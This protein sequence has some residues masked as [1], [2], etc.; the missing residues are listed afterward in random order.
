MA[1]LEPVI[2]KLQNGIETIT[3]SDNYKRWL[4]TC[5]AFHKY[6]WSNCILISC[7]CEHASR[8]AGFSTWKKLNRAV[9]KGEKGIQILAPNPIK[10]Y[11]SKEEAEEISGSYNVKEKDGK[12]FLELMRF[13]P[14]YVFDIS[15]TEGEELP[16]IKCEELTGNVSLTLFDAV[17]NISPCEIEFKGIDNGYKGY[18]SPPT[19]KIAIQEGM[20]ELQSL[21]TMLHEITHAI[22]HCRGGEEEKAA[23]DIKELEAESVAF[24]VCDHFGL[25]TSEYSFAYLAGWQEDYKEQAKSFLKIIKKTSQTLIDSINKELGIVETDVI[26]DKKAIA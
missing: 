8:V 16:S 25:D 4:V 6:S 17:K 14:V 15:Q 3:N 26:A 7:Q 5:S 24:I 19:N 1:D 9:K 18:Y 23:R 21:K 13:R 11:L 22:L 12:Y 20:S 10:R 2:A